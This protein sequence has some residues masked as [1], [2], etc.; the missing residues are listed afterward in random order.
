MYYQVNNVRLFVVDE[1]KKAPA[2][3]FLHF[4]GGSS[5][6]WAQVTNLLTTDHRCIRLDL[7]G[8]GASEKPETGYDIQ[9]M[10]DDVLALAGELHLDNYILVGHSMGGKIA[11]AVAARKPAGLKKMILVAPSPATPTVPPPD[12]LQNMLKVYKSV[13]AMYFGIY[14]VLGGGNLP[15]ATKAWVVEDMQKHNESSRLGWPTIALGEDVSKGVGGI[16]IPVLVI[17]GENDIIDPPAH[18]EREV[19]RK[20]PGAKMSVVPNVGH[21]SMVQ[22]PEAVAELIHEFCQATSQ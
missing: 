10:A 18:M 17:A 5:R 19:V 16:R 2:L 20:I 12:R 21:L 6:T 11:Q 14:M 15:A 4:Y 1:G 8:W 13:D 9:T 3:L 7:R 22:A